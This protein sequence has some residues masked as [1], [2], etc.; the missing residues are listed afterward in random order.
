MKIVRQIKHICRGWN[1]NCARFVWKR[2]IFKNHFEGYQLKEFHSIL[3]RLGRSREAPGRLR[4]TLFPIEHVWLSSEF[5]KWM[6][7]NFA[8][9]PKWKSNRAAKFSTRWFVNG[10]PYFGGWIFNDLDLFDI[11]DEIE[12]LIIEGEIFRLIEIRCKKTK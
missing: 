3:S 12:N 9:W 10:S 4:V 5:G 8:H 2:N 11:L 6:P 1:P 7:D